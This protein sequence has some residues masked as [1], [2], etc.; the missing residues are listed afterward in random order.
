L[1]F[2]IF[3]WLRKS[4]YPTQINVR[5][6]RKYKSW[7]QG[8]KRIDHFIWNKTCRKYKITGKPLLWVFVYYRKNLKS[9]AAKKDNSCF[10]YSGKN[11]E[12]IAL[13]IDHRAIG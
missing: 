13:C 7:L 1:Y 9:H 4:A 11:Q 12:G 6:K 10:I 5:F 2:I 8:L 3:F